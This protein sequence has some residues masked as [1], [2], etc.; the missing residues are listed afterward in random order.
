MRIFEWMIEDIHLLVRAHWNVGQHQIQPV[1]LQLPGEFIQTSG[2]DHH[3]GSRIREQRLN[4]IELEILGKRSDRADAEG[5]PPLGIG[6]TEASD[7]VVSGRENCLRVL[8]GDASSIPQLKGS[9]T[10]VEPRASWI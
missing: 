6:L 3:F 4:E 8:Q 5:A 2:H 10:S 1:F 9:P 7:Q